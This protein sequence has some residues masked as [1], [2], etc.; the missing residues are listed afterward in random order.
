MNKLTLCKRNDSDEQ[1]VGECIELLNKVKEK[2]SIV[3]SILNTSQLEEPE[4]KELRDKIRGVAIDGISVKSQGNGP[5]PI[6]RKGDAFGK[7]C[8]LLNYEDDKLKSV[9]PHSKNNK[10]NDIIPYLKK[11]IDSDDINEVFDS[12]SISERDIARIISTF[13]ELIEEGLAFDDVEVDTNDGRIDAVFKTSNNEHLL[14]EIEI[15]AKDNAIGQVQRFKIAY[16]KKYDIPEN[17]IRLGIVCAKISNSRLN[18]CKGAG[19][20]VYTLCLDRKV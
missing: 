19:I 18:A 14:T 15:E 10:R 2:H 3:Y 1:E 7:V 9:Y 11:L 17:K 13:P 16:S 20:E 6:S 8:I 5:L 4:G 12:E